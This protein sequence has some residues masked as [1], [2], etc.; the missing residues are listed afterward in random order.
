M[1]NTAGNIIIV[2]VL[3]L[4]VSL[5]FIGLFEV[6]STTTCTRRLRTMGKYT[7]ARGELCEQSNFRAGVHKL[8]TEYVQQQARELGGK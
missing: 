1:S 4:T 8:H 6:G 5:F 7:E 3:V 2:T